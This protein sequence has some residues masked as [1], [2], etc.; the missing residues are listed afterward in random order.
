MLVSSLVST[1]K[2]NGRVVGQRLGGYWF[3]FSI[4]DPVLVFGLRLGGS[5]LKSLVGSLVVGCLS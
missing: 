5:G 2:P 4:I 3:R 1:Q